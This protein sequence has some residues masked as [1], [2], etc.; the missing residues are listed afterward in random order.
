MTYP[1][2]PLPDTSQ[3]NL[4]VATLL[5]F[6]LGTLGVHRFYVGKVGTGIAMIFTLGGL[7]IWTLIDF[8][9]LLVQAFKDSDGQTLR[10]TSVNS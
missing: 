6:F 7:G 3:K 9:M 10:W 2:A 1:A 8:I 4:L 5:C